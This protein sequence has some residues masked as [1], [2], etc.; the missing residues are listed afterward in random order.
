MPLHL[1]LA[2]GD[3]DRVRPLADGRVRPEGIELNTIFLDPE[4]CFFRMFRFCEFDVCEISLSSYVLRRCKGRDDIIA[5][6]VFLSRFFRHSSIYIN[7]KSGIRRPE[8]LKGKRVGLGEYQM[9]ATVWVRGFLQ[10]E[11]GVA[12]EDVEWV[13]GGYK[14]PGREERE[15]LSLA[16]RIRCVPAGPGKNL[17]RMLL[18][19]EIDALISARV[20]AIWGHPDVERLFPD[21]GAAERE[22]YR[23]TKLFPIMHAVGIR[24]EVYEAHPWVAQSLMKAFVQAKQIA[25]AGLYEAPALRYTMPFLLSYLEEQIQVFGDNLWPYGLDAN[26]R[27]L[28]V[29]LRY[30]REQ[31]LIT[32]V[33]PLEALFAPNCLEETKI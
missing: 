11:Y 10:D 29:F 3:Y 21:F 19:G 33:P 5:I 32:D 20:P 22:Y 9:T 23:R 15:P 16:P 27:D 2:C 8:D 12:P 31:G 4:E 24:R 18:D 25:L 7:R 6:P 14:Q 13:T 17:N 28:S 26:R 30:M 1:T